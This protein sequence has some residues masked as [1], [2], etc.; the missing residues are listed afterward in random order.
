MHIKLQKEGFHT[1]YE[2]LIYHAL[3][4]SYEGG[5]I[6]ISSNGSVLL[7]GFKSFD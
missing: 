5:K 2:P 4:V 7:Y 1:S 6:I 3:K